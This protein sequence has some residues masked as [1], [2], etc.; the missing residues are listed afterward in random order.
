[1]WSELGAR[2]EQAEITALASRLPPGGTLVDV[3]ANVGLHSVQL[4]KLVADLRVLAFEPVGNTFAILQ[5]NI[6]KNDVS[7]R[8][9]A[10]QVAV[11]DRT[12]T[13]RLTTRLQFGNFVIPEGAQVAADA[14]EEVASRTLDELLEATDRVDAIKCDVE[15]AE[16]A[17]LTGATK[18]LERFRP[19]VL[20][21]VDERWARRYGNSGA[22]VFGFLTQRGY[23]YERFVDGQLVP[24]SGSLVQDIGQGSN[25]LF[26]SALS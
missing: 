13:L 20:I 14:S 12:G 8:V 1:M 18:T 10:R 16:L 19:T 5:R 7:A 6:A 21:E 4:A 2:Y 15:G 22:D 3:G 17:V 9:Q 23:G 25:F 11:S 26:S 24:P